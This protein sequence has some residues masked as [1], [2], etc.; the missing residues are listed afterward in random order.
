MSTLIKA[1][2]VSRGFFGPRLTFRLKAESQKKTA[3]YSDFFGFFH[4]RH[5]KKGVNKSEKNTFFSYFPYFLPDPFYYI[6][7]K[8]NLR[9][10]H[11]YHHAGTKA[12]LTKIKLK[13]YD[14]KNFIK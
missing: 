3:Y 9:R 6:N 4:K 14:D 7:D 12:S 5:M 13:F 10:Y 1:R 2:V 8:Y 11:Q